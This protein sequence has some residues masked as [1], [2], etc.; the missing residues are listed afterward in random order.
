MAH[1]HRHTIDRCLIMPQRC[2]MSLMVARD[3]SQLVH[4]DTLR[5]ISVEASSVTES[6]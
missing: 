3:R 6:E 1:L 5:R 2:V 4:L